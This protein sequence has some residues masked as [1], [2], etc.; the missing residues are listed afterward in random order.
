MVGNMLDMSV[1]KRLRAES[2]AG[3]IG[4]CYESDPW[5]FSHAESAHGPLIVVWDS[6]IVIYFRDFGRQLV[7]GDE[8]HGVDDGLAAELDALGMLVNWWFMRD[9]RFVVP[10]ALDRDE[11]RPVQKD[12]R[13]RRVESIRAVS[14]ALTFQ[15]DEW[16]NPDN[17][18]DQLYAEVEALDAQGSDPFD[19]LSVAFPDERSGDTRIMRE[20]M[21]FGADV[22]LTCD[23]RFIKRGARLGERLTKVMA[24]TELV[25]RLL[26]VGMH[27]FW[28]GG[29]LDHPDCPYAY[30]DVIAGDLGKLPLL[31]SAL[32]DE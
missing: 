23:R 6:N 1:R 27:E 31:L 32:G 17:T 28:R 15:L 20:A 22:V 4:F 3:G 2:D 9:I 10:P 7:D 13:S 12:I 8:I 21:L 29:L 19:S 26:H 30:P 24:P 18:D 11:K 5:L 14:Q 25:E 16:G